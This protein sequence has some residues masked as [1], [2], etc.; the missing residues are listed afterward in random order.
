MLAFYVYGETRS[1]LYN[2][3]IACLST[4]R[5]RIDWLACDLKELAN[6]LASS[7][8]PFSVCKTAQL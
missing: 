7:S 8:S 6:D 4:C 5:E 3:K 1:K 2:F